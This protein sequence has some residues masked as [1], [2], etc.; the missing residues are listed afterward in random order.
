MNEHVYT[1]ETGDRVRER[2][3]LVEVG[4]SP[5]AQAALGHLLHFRPPK[6]GQLAREGEHLFVV[7]GSLTAAEFYSPASGSVVRHAATDA[8]ISDWMV[9]IKRDTTQAG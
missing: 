7:E 4:L 6:L 2:D 8:S 1:T 9:V 5:E 3:G